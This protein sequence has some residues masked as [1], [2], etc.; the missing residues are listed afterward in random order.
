[1]EYFPR[2]T[3]EKLGSATGLWGTRE[4]T[5]LSTVKILFYYI[6][7]FTL[8]FIYNLILYNI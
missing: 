5:Y 7:N 8:H 6:C 1:M 2:C 3:Q 4:Q